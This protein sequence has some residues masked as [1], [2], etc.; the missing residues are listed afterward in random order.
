MSGIMDDREKALENSYAHQEQ[1]DFATEAR[2]CKLFGLMVAEKLGLEGSDASTYAAEV[3]E[4][5][6]EE[7]GFEDVMR[8]VTA[9]LDKK[10]VEYSDRLLRMDLDK[11]LIE[12]RKQLKGE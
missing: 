3:V 6:L 7:K 5:N 9:D 2:C 11:A 10:G 8:K 1:L 12:A 4:S